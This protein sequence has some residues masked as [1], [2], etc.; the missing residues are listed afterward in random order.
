MTPLSFLTQCARM[1]MPDA[2]TALKAYNE[3][4]E[5]AKKNLAFVQQV[6][7]METEEEMDERGASDVTDDS[8]DAMNGLITKA[9]KMTGINRQVQ[10]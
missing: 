8:L 3:Q 6:A 9:R 4:R 5:A 7:R 2:R 1:G 10:S